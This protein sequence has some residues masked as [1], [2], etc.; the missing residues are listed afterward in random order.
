QRLGD[1]WPVPPRVALGWRLV[2]DRPDAL[3]GLGVVNRRG[4]RAGQIFK[5][6]KSLTSKTN[7][8]QADCGLR[9]VELTGNLP[10]PRSLRRLQN[11]ACPQQQPLLSGHDEVTGSVETSTPFDP[12]ASMKS[13][14]GRK[15][16]PA[17]LNFIERFRKL[18]GRTPTGSQIR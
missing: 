11:N 2:E 8:P 3:V 7:P 14:R 13:R 18:Y 9:R 5:S 12:S 17:V 6:V 1:Q 15:S 16:D 10:C 4:A